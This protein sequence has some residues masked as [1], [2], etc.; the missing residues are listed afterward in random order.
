MIA[1]IKSAEDKMRR[2]ERELNSFSKIPP[3]KM[4]KTLAI[5]VKKLRETVSQVRTKA[6]SVRRQA[7][8]PNIS[9]IKKFESQVAKTVTRLR[10]LE[11]QV[12]QAQRQVAEARQFTEA[13]VRNSRV[14]SV[15]EQAA[16]GGRNG[17]RP[18]NSA[19]SQIDAA[20]RDAENRLRTVSSTLKET[21]SLRSAIDKLNS[22]LNPIDKKVRDVAKVVNK[23]LGFKVPFTKKRVSFSVR[24]ILESPDR[25]LGV[26]LKPLTKLAKKLLSPLTKKMQFDVKPPA[27]LARLSASLDR[28]KN[29]S[30]NMD[31]VES[32][33]RSATDS[34]S[35]KKVESSLQQF[36]SK[37]SGIR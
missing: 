2:L 23:K 22:K 17:I 1:A 26:A 36:V 10:G 25:V 37:T 15:V 8:D 28:L 20:G 7:I 9:R 33:L 13:N 19:L 31:A 18:L 35:L 11:S 34:S 5:G 14:H 30:L 6:E 12:Q 32:K 27:E 3:L 29:L 4:M 16:R 24:T 21:I